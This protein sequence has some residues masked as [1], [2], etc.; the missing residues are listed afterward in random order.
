[1]RLGAAQRPQDVADPGDPKP[2]HMPGTP[3]VQQ[4]AEAVD[5]R[6]DADRRGHPGLFDRQRLNVAAAEREAPDRHAGGVDV[7]QRTHVGE[8]GAPV[9]ALALGLHQETGTAAAAAEVPVV[10][11]EHRV[12]GFGET[13]GEGVE[14]LLAHAGEARGHDDTGG[15]A[16]RARRREE[17]SRALLPSRS[18]TNLL[19]L[20]LAI[21]VRPICPHTIRAW[22]TW[23]S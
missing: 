11:G 16:G 7:L 14:A 9:V 17:P 10:E 20:H 21:L 8:R 12:A 1:V 3:D 18:K 6:R 5:H 23:R 22:P 2:G 13:L 19:P 4:R 15:A